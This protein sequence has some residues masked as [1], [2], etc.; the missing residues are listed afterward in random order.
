MRITVF[1]AAG[2][3]GRC[4]VEEALRRGHEVLAV[5]RREASLAGLPAA[6]ERVLGDASDADRVAELSAGRHL[7]LSATRPAA[8]R[9]A[10]LALV[11]RALLAGVA[12]SGARLLLVGGA[13]SLTVPGSNGALVL[14]DPRYVPPAWRAIALACRDQLEVCRAAA[15][16]DWTYLSPPASLE[17]GQRTGSYRS[18]LDE[19]L[20]DRSG[21]SRISIE[22]LAVA[23]LDEAEHPAHRRRRFTVAY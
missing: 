16:A 14:D 8:G 12:R 2:G 6:A 11:A 19:L 3:V 13:G 10:E 17:A 5:A 22:D 23:L 15:E 4:V 18:G 21:T 20:A 1:G 7:V 9:E